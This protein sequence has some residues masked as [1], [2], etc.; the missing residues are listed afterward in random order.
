M[1]IGCLSILIGVLTF[2]ILRFQWVSAATERSFGFR[3][4][5]GPEGYRVVGSATPPDELEETWLDDGPVGTPARV[6]SVKVE[7]TL[8]EE[9]SG[10]GFAIG[11]RGSPP[12]ENGPPIPALIDQSLRIRVFG[13][14]L[15]NRVSFPERDS[16]LPPDLKSVVIDPSTIGHRLHPPQAIDA[17]AEIGRILSAVSQAVVRDGPSELIA[18][19]PSV[20]AGG[21]ERWEIRPGGVLLYLGVVGVV[22]V[23]VVGPLFYVRAQLHR[24]RRLEA[25]TPKESG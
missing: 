10:W 8:K 11:R 19:A 6:T 15:G 16:R 20:A 25:V 9:Q 22:G 24:V 17:P 13:E 14:I 4:T 21:S 2:C 1:K 5:L 12:G 3:A 23:V 18:H 7:V